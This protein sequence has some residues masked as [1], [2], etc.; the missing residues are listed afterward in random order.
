MLEVLPLAEM[1][2]VH[3]IMEFVFGGGEYVRQ[4][5]DRMAEE[6][7]KLVL[8]D[9]IKSPLFLVLQKRYF[10]WGVSANSRRIMGHANALRSGAIELIDYI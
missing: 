8:I 2:A 4:V 9:L 1:A 10:T 3:N 7:E 6:M 5:T